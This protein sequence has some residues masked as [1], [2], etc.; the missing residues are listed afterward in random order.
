MTDELFERVARRAEE[1][2]RILSGRVRSEIWS[3]WDFVYFSGMTLTTVGYGDILPN[4]TSVR[5]LV[6]AEV[7]VGIF[8]FVFVLNLLLSVLAQRVAKRMARQS[9][10][11]HEPP[12]II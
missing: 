3:Y 9:R 12:A 7:L 2:E 4:T 8:L 6:L 11:Q 1:Q 5:I 10:S